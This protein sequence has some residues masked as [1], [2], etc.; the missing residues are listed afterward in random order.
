MPANSSA[1]HAAMNKSAGT[2]NPPGHEALEA[3]IEAAIEPW[4]AH[5]YWRDDFKQWRE[6]RLRQEDYQATNLKDVKTALG[7]EVRGKTVLD[8]G[9]GMGGLSVALL[10]DYAAQGLHLQAMDYNKDYCRIAILRARRYGIQLPII[11]AAGEHLPYRSGI[12]DLVICLDVLEHVADAPAVLREMYRVLRPGGHVL[13]TVPNRHAFRD[14]HYHLPLINWLPRGL[15]ERIVERT[16]RTKTGGL[17]QDRQGLS[18]LNTYTWGQFE[19]LARSIGYR[20]HDQVFERLRR[21]EVRLLTGMRKRLLSLLSRTP[22]LRL[23][24]R[25]YR[26]GWQGTF[27]IKLDKP[28]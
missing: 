3:A 18:D 1:E 27:Q 20:L 15:A 26:Y 9:S 13:T 21:G 7:D 6:R 24:Y 10:R 16:G 2:S 8:L 14:P 25:A 12:F 17:L 23:M 4:L 5:M 11:A 28:R 19:Q 22:L